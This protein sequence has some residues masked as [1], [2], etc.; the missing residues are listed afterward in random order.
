[1]IH[2]NDKTFCASD[3]QVKKCPHNRQLT[4]S[5]TKMAEKSGLPIAHLDFSKHCDDYIKPIKQSIDKG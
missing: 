5:I 4:Y 1:M 3:C 2:F